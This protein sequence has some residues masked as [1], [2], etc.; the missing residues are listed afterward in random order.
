LKKVSNLNLDGL[1]LLVSASLEH[2]GAL[3]AAT[4]DLV[5]GN[6]LL[7]AES[8]GSGKITAVH[9]VGIESLLLDVA[10]GGSGLVVLLAI[11]SLDGS[12]ALDI[13]GVAVGNTRVLVG[14]D[15]QQVASLGREL[16]TTGTVGSL[17][18][19]EEAVVVSNQVPHKSVRHF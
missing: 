3:A 13:N 18:L 6:A 8:S 11:S 9:L 19:V 12:T 4:L 2:E 7:D 14:V 5:G 15:V 10:D 1:A 17:S 16:N